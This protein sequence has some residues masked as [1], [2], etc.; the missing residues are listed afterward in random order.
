MAKR[1]DHV[2]NNIY[3]NFD[4]AYSNNPTNNRQMR[5]EQMYM[6][7]LSEV[8]M[9]R[10]KWSG[11]PNTVDERFLEKTLYENGLAIFFFENQK[12]NA[13]LALRGSPAGQL[14]M[15][16][17]P[18]AYRVLGN[19][20]INRTVGA[21][22]CVPIWS[23]FS[24]SPDHDIVRIFSEELATLDRSIEINSFNLRQN[25]IIVAE[26]NQRLSFANFNRQ[27]EEG[28]SAIFTTNN[29]L[30]EGVNVLDVGG[31]P[32]SLPAL[33]EA[34]SKAWNKC[35]LLLGIDNNPGEDKKERI[36]SAE[37]D[38]NDE[39]ILHQRSISLNARRQACE[40]INRRYGL[41]VSVDYV[42]GDNQEFSGLIDDFAYSLTQ[43]EAQRELE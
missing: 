17:N 12:F 29:L 15:Y 13:Y 5:R 24:R 3:D 40:V 28:A 8:S 27:I 33:T 23:N 34:R 38:A 42:K 16:D 18:L 30:Q 21:R 20:Q 35:M 32:R 14:N 19:T 37:V 4:R 41:G 1:P 11:L 9:N 10:F 43:E 25:R 26:E 2:K 36:A 6:R 31:D 39:Q 22:D 7:V